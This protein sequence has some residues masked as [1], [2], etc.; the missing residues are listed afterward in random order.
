MR[1]HRH[2]VSAGLLCLLLAAPAFGQTT[3]GT[4]PQ[5]APSKQPGT[6]APTAPHAAT[7][8]HNDPQ[9]QRAESLEA[10]RVRKSGE[11][12]YQRDAV[13]P[14]SASPGGAAPQEPSAEKRDQAG[15]QGKK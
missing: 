8:P 11:L 7:W 9:R 6:D 10:D 12:G 15:A 2:A 5:P 4:A 14:D 1:Q 3:T 13:A